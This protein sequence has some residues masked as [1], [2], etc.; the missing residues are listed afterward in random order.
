MTRAAMDA[1]KALEAIPG[2]TVRRDEPLS[3]HTSFRLGGPARV[4]IEPSTIEQL[5]LALRELEGDRWT[6]IGGGTNVLFDDR[7]FD[8]VVVCT[9]ALHGC[10]LE[11]NDLR[12]SAGTSL[13]ETIR[14]AAEAGRSGIERLW[15][16]PGSVGGAVAGNAGAF[17]CATFDCLQEVLLVGPDGEARAVAAGE[18][19]FGY[20]RGGIPPRHVVAEARWR[21]CSGDPDVIRAA[22][23]DARRRRAETQP[24][25]QPSAGCVFRN[26]PGDAA[27]RLIDVAGLKGAR[28]GGAMVSTVHANYIVLDG[29]ACSDD[30][31]RL[32]DLVRDRVG[33]T[34]GVVLETELVVVG[35]DHS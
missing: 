31:R 34:S 19:S 25:G 21:V 16:I 4:W 35:A 10:V 2:L 18:L 15:G 3:L 28:V 24:W 30:V 27:G 14:V 7:G 11:R 32:V 8:G 12:A 1:G 9:H 29:P 20:R 17:G 13:A 26:P 5:S 22:M 23:E 33:E 6:V